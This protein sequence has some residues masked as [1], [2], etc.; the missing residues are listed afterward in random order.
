MKIAGVAPGLTGA[1]RA[2]IARD[3]R[4]LWRRRGDALQ[5]ALFALLVLV[6]FALALGGEP[7]LLPKVAGGVLGS[8]PCSRGCWRWTLCSAAMP[9]MA[10]R[11]VDAGAG[12]AV[13]VVLV[14]TLV[15]WATTSLPLLLATPL[16]AELLHLPRAHYRFCLRRS[17][18]VRNC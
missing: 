10:A 13:L 17:R 16:L 11:T 3:L 4:L 7:Q 18:S 5:P 1:A 9:R 15:H 14:R 12:A 6:L 2:L 8:P